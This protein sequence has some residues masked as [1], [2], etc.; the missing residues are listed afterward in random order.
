[1]IEAAFRRWLGQLVAVV[2]VILALVSA[3][4][5]LV[6]FFWPVVIASILLLGTYL[7]WDNLRELWT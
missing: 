7:L 5:L 3:V 4:I 2:T 6:N 1:V